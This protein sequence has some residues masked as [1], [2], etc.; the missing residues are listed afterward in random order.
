MKVLDLRCAMDHAFEGWFASEQDFLSQQER[1][2]VQC[3]LC[4]STG[5][6]KALSAPRLNLK[7]G[8]RKGSPNAQE[9]GTGT[10]VQPAPAAAALQ[11]AWLRLARELVAQTEDVGERFAAEARRMH[12]KEIPERPIRG[13]ASAQE[14][15]ELLQDGIPVLMLPL[16]ESAKTTLQ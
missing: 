4:G 2:L 10:A 5:V 6:H 8:R 1:Q 16:P 15:E 14:A 3:P 13:Q 7:S 12:E 9:A 11:A